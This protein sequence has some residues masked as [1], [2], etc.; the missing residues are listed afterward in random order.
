MPERDPLEELFRQHSPRL[1]QR[2]NLR[3]WRRLESRL[4]RRNGSRR[5]QGPMRPW[6]YAAA[7]VLLCVLAAGIGT[8]RVNVS[9]DVLAQR[10][11]T[12]EDLDLTY[13]ENTLRPTDRYDGITEGSPDQF[14]Q[15]R[16]TGFPELLPAPKYRL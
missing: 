2:P 12:I 15:V 6:L 7:A 11:Q 8:Q 5:T 13:G 4:D 1:E 9:E 3:T 14:L 16:N 10:P